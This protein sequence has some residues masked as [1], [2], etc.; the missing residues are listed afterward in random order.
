M[1][2]MEVV[3]QVGFPIAIAIWS[4]FQLKT[5]WEKISEFHLTLEEIIGSIED[6]KDLLDKNASI[7]TEILTTLKILNALLSKNGGGNE[8]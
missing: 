1:D 2:L 6:I 7:Q 5:A 3:K 4:L 8:C